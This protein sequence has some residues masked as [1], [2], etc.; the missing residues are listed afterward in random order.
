MTTRRIT[1][2]TEPVTASEVKT[3]L[4]LTGT[5]FDT[6]IALLI[7]SMRLLAE[8][9][10]GRALAVSTW[11]LK[12]DEFP[13]NEIRLLWPPLVSVQSITYVDTAGATITLAGAAYYV[14]LHSEP[15]WVLPA[16]NTDWPATHDS[17]N[18]VTVSYTAGTAAPEAV[19]LWIAA[20]IRADLDGA[21]AG[22]I[23]GLLD[24][25]KVY[26]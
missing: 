1:T 5:D 18:A 17:A 20:M 7:P 9:I 21:D 11:Q 26:A 23:D 10:T 24:A 6:R 4:P 3:L 2:T 12:L 22:S 13:H 19:K 25:L 15:G 8:Q 14:D 16:A